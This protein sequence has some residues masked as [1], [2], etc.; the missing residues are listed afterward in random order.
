M[1]KRKKKSSDTP[2]GKSPTSSNASLAGISPRALRAL[3]KSLANFGK[4]PNGP[5]LSDDDQGGTP[6]D[7]AQELVYQAWE[8]PNPAKRISLAKRALE[9]CSDCADA[10]VLLA[11]EQSQGP[12]QAIEQFRL[13]VEAGER[14][15]GAE[16]FEE[17]VGHFWGILETRPYMRAR[18]AL[19]CAHWEFGERSIAIE[20]A[21][22]L[23]RLNPNDNQGIRDI[24]ITWLLMSGRLRDAHALWKRYEHDGSAVWAWS[25]A[26]MDFIEHGDGPKANANLEQAM[27]RNPHLAPLLLGREALP[28][29]APDFI[30][31]GDRDEAAAYVFDNEELWQQTDGA[32][33]WLA[34]AM[35]V[36]R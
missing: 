16:C 25:L 21:Q 2:T 32:L 33:R 27:T 36:K 20:H 31:I 34:N 12:E 30:G 26:L 24:L 7:R 4:L 9:V 10:H 22:N 11:E 28:D 14:A 6:L 29:H 35:P 1:T 13:A 18:W 5:S 3:E 17:D 19:A 23:L 8:I 15:L